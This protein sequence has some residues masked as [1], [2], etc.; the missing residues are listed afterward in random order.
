ME[1]Y[2]NL[3][4][5]FGGDAPSVSFVDACHYALCDILQYILENVTFLTACD[6][7]MLEILVPCLS[8]K[9]CFSM[10]SIGFYMFTNSHPNKM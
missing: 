1:D 10:F 7:S 6:I 9:L 4:D 2:I 3:K 8:K 5:A